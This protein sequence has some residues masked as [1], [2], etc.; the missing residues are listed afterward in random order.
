MTLA[1]LAYIP[2][3][4]TF[5]FLAFVLY[6]SPFRTGCLGGW[7][8]QCDFG[9]GDEAKR[10]FVRLAYEEEAGGGLHIT[11]ARNSSS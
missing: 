7:S 5:C 6:K 2:L 10:T 8:G 1:L 9:Q 3:R 11:R 4:C